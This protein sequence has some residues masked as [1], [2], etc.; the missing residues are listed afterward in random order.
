MIVHY[1]DTRNISDFNFN[2]IW[3]LLSVVP[4]H[5]YLSV[6]VPLW[7]LLC[8]CCIHFIFYGL[9]RLPKVILVLIGLTALFSKDITE[10]LPSPFMFNNS[11]YWIAY[12]ILGAS[13][14]R[15]FVTH[16]YGTTRKIIAIITSLIIFMALKYGINA[17]TGS[18]AIEFEIIS[19]IFMAM[20]II[21]LFDGIKRLDFLRYYGKNSIHILM[22][23]IILLIPL[24]RLMHKFYPEGNPFLGLIIAIIVAIALVPVINLLNRYTPYLVGKSDLIKPKAT[25][26]ATLK[27]TNAEA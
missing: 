3:D 21:S 20:S 27:G 15:W 25:E 6:N 7:F 5:D 24:E 17:P 22:F 1:W 9:H 19:F 4:Q 16:I 18:L 26:P 13:A 14:G 10:S 2:M 23:H 11:L 8:L 12:F